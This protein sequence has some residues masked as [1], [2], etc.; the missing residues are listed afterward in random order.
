MSL[1]VQTFLLF[2]LNFLDAILTIYWVEKGFASEGN[3]L[4]AGLL[5]IGVLPFLI[6]K[7]AV[8]AV[9]SVVLW[10]WG[11]LQLAKYG[12]AVALAV[13]VCLMGVHVFTGLVGF[14]VI[15]DNFM[16]NVSL[17]S[18]QAFAFFA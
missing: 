9:A 17:W 5:D 7:I 12:L 2:T 11:N 6:V 3:Q 1:S 8:G 15:S 10:R 4:M 13:Y 16:S 14:G 18:N